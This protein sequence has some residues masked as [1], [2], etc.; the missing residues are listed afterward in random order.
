MSGWPL[1]VGGDG[2]RNRRLKEIKDQS[3]N[4][5]RCWLAP[6]E[7]RLGGP[8]DFLT[9]TSCCYATINI[10]LLNNVL[11]FDGVS[12]TVRDCRLAAKIA[13]TGESAR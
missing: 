2:M 13:D 3:D 11:K 8:A 12:A 5:R 7:R 10:F 4:W 9:L 6:G 1:N